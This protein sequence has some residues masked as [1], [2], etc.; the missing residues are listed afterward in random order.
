MKILLIS[1]MYPCDKF[2]NYGIFVKNFER[3]LIDKN[4]NM[5]KVVLKKESKKVKKIIKYIKFYLDI[6]LKIIIKN[7]DLIYVH[8]ASH[9]A[10]P[11]ILANKIKKINLF[12]NV[13]GSDVVPQKQNQYKYQKYVKKILKISKKVIVPSIYFKEL[14][15][16]KYNINREKVEIYP[17]GGINEENFY[18]IN[19]KTELKKKYNINEKV[20]VIGFVG[21]IDRGKGWD[22]FLKSL[23]NLVDNNKIEGKVALIVGS[24]SQIKD[25]NNMINKLELN[26]YIIHFNL[27]PQSELNNIYNIIDVFCF[28]TMGE[29]LGLVGLEAMMCGVPVI[30]SKVG[31]LPEYIIENETGK[32]INK[33]DHKD[34]SNKIIE[35]Y[36]EINNNDVNKFIYAKK[37]IK[38]AREYESKKVNEKIYEVLL[39]EFR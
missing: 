7:Y 37:C 21:R 38:K 6:F 31:A 12:V 15:I 10:I 20:F 34:L 8:Y 16:N 30:G 5:E 17:S 3:G 18:F 1:N 36:N 11:I 35:I 26:E 33:S 2:P 23:K 13:H 27:L 14:V 39:N 25:F 19:E 28:P 22:I 32:L 9:S 4:I 29:S 24:G